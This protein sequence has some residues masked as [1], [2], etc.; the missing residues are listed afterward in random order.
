MSSIKKSHKI[1]E[2]RAGGF[3]MFIYHT[4]DCCLSTAFVASAVIKFEP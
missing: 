1:T 2:R 3:I 4:V